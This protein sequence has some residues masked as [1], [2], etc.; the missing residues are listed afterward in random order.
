[1]VYYRNTR[2]DWARQRNGATHSRTHTHQR[3]DVLAYKLGAAPP[4]TPGVQDRLVVQLVLRQGPRVNSAEPT[5]DSHRAT[6]FS[7]RVAFTFSLAA[8]S[9]RRLMSLATAWRSTG[10]DNHCHSHA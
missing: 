1:M 3:I 10:R 9:R 5:S 8:W 7:S 2:L 6:D 4:T